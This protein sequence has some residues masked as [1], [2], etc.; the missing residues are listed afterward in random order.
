MRIVDEQTLIARLA[1]LPDGSRIVAPGNFATPFTMLRIVDQALDT[2]R[3]NMLNA[4][5]GIPDRPG[6]YYETS[7]VGAGMRGHPRLSYYPARLSMVPHLYAGRLAPQ[8]VVLHVS[9]PRGTG[10]QRT[11]SM[12]IEVNVLP[13]AIEACRSQ[14]GVVVAAINKHMPYTEGHSVISTEDIDLAIEI[15][16]PLLTHEPKQ[17]DDDSQR[18]G[19]LVAARIVD[20]SA[21]QTGIGAVPDAVLARLGER[22][23]LRM[24][25]ET[26]ADGVLDLERQGAFNKDLPLVTTF[27]FGSQE[28]YDWADGNDRLRVLRTEKVNDPARIAKNPLMVSVNTA[29]QV[30]LF[31]QANA[32]RINHTIYSGFGG[33]TDF[34]VGAMHSPGGQ[35]MI[36]LKSWHPR[37]DVSTIV[38]SLKDPTTSMQMSCVV[39]EQ[40]VTE[41][42]GFTQEEQAVGLITNSAHPDAREGLWK[43]AKK[44]GLVKKRKHRAG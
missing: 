29:L 31:L 18:I 43:Q 4:Q 32:S 28:L 44:L 16:E 14:G 3:L 1:S 15:D 22:K 20:G 41:V 36:A 26:F 23:G 19:D 35:A 40:G 39:T 25:T 33:Q 24:W 8:V 34:I 9:S 10:H 37:A 27:L 13:A 11:V 17:P 42:Y 2:Y 30:D 38:G 12:G 21:L 6:V 5:C 7:F